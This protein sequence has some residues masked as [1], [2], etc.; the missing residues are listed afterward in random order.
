MK[1]SRRIVSSQ[2]NLTSPEES[3]REQQRTDDGRT[4]TSNSEGVASHLEECS[5]S[6]SNRSRNSAN[7]EEYDE[8]A[9]E[10]YNDGHYLDNLRQ[11]TEEMMDCKLLEA[12]SYC[13]IEL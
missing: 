10:E 5:T 9:I 11:T 3:E 8:T 1:R 4:D 2:I 6:D 13:L 7:Q 12:F